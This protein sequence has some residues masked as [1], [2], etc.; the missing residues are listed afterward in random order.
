MEIIRY[1]QY[2]PLAT[3]SNNCITIGNFDGVHLGHQQLIN[4][5]VEQAKNTGGLATVVTMHP[6]PNQ[7][8]N[9]KQSLPLINSFKQKARLMAALGVDVLCVL[10]FNQKL[11]SMTALR[12][13]QDI[14]KQ[15]LGA[16]Y[17]LVGDDFE[18]GANRSGNAAFLNQQCQQ[19]G[20]QFEQQSSVML[21]NQRV[22][23]SLVRTALHCG[24]FVTVKRY[25]GRDYV[26]SGRV[27]HGKKL[28][29]TLGFPTLNIHFKNGASALH[30][31][32]VVKVK[33]KSKWHEA[34]AS[35]GFNPTVRDSSKRLEVHV[36][37]FEGDVY[38]EWI[39]VLFYQ[40]LRNEV[41]FDGLS[42]LKAAIAADV[43][44]AR[45]YF[46]ENTG[47]LV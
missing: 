37:D 16:Q 27:R 30:G 7:Y 14:V 42:A 35:V 19:A 36:L 26:V 5:V 43:K 32:Y 25:L 1:P 11:A 2:F 39:E 6:L 47:D 22:S 40:K 21:S 23:S 34:V 33:I 4:R 10:N 8:F 28:G 29:R 46:E 31:I 17:L 44:A 3:P 9:G 41:E 12:F 24:D 13:F 45:Q 15:G 20:I 38:H 18:F